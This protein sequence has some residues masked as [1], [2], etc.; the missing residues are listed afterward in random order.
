[1][2][3]VLL[4]TGEHTSEISFPLGGIGTGCIGLAGNGRLIDWEIFNKPNKGS[5]NGFSH[6]AIRAERDGEVIDARVLNSELSGSYVGALGRKWFYEGFGWGP[7]R[8][9]LAGMPHFSQHEFTGEFPFAQ[10]SFSDPK[11]PGSVALLAFNPFIP[12]N[13]DDSAL[14]AAF[15]EIRVTNTTDQPLTYAVV[16]VLANPFGV[17]GGYNELAKAGDLHLLSMRTDQI[18]PDAFEYGDLTIATDAEQCSYQEY[19]Y[20]GA[21]TDALEIYWRDLLKPGPLS[22]RHYPRSERFKSS[23]WHDHDNGHIAAH[24]TL[25][26]GEA[27]TI[28][29]VIAW[30]FPNNK[31]YWKP[32]ADSQ[33]ERAGLRNAWKNHYATRWSDSTAT[34]RYAL[35]EWDRLYEATRL[36][37]ETLFASDLPRVALDAIS[38]TLS[39]LKS[40]TVLRLED[41]TFYGWE[42]VGE[43][44]GCCEGSCT[45]VW[46]YAQAVAFLFPRLERSMRTA[47]YRYNVD[48]D[49]GSHFRIQLPLGVRYNDFRPCA[50]GQFGDVLKTY[51]DWKISGDDAWLKSLWPTIKKTIQY[52]WS[53]RNP[54]RWDPDKTGVLWGRQHH[55][56]DMELFGAN[57]WLTGFYLGALK[58]GAEMAA[59]LGE[60][61]FSQELLAMFDRG[62]HWV[63]E[64]LFNGDYYGQQVDLRDHDL[65]RSFDRDGDQASITYWSEEHGEIKYQIGEGCEIDMVVAQWHA[66]LYGLGEIFDPEQVRK[67]LAAI[68][69]YNFKRSMKDE[70]NPWRLYTINNEAGTVICAWPEDRYKPM[71]PL[72]YS[73]ETMTGFEYSAG[74]LMIQAGLMDE[75]LTCIEAI[76]ARFDGRKRNPWNEIECGSNYA[77]AMA[78][79]ALLNTFSGFQFDM[80]RGEV[81]FHPLGQGDSQFFW[82]LDSGWGKYVQNATTRELHVLYGNLPLTAFAVTG[83]VRQVMLD[84]TPVDF[85]HEGNR[86]VFVHPIDIPS[87]SRL[88]IEIN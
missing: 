80:V 56:L 10:I 76:R 45:H 13:E 50:D 58:A 25:K 39:V 36:F 69:R 81:G 85:R 34:S 86:I 66:N 83:E 78:S 46:N 42:G 47:N 67:T 43:S 59:H 41:G 75:G 28:R 23:G 29:Y 3:N 52:A 22:N 1:M 63:D 5:V 4:Y 38:S 61:D 31:N 77:R 82:S 88:H 74:I 79:Y 27:R 87:G 15:F 30:N 12:T 19:W 18:A 73:Q 11:F 17:N 24:V 72:P 60:S 21:W 70:Y 51:R 62:K 20:R 57:A 7:Q 49:G 44:A 37:K 14:P 84:Q 55:T 48:P 35:D 65:L 40:P 64:H 33:A 26:P 16:G 8:E 32:D 9:T 53:P 71:I 2:T 68:F 54:D 6:F